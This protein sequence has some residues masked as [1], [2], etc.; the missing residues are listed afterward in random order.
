MIGNLSRHKHKRWKDKEKENISSTE[1]QEG[2]PLKDSNVDENEA[3]D[4]DSKGEP[5]PKSEGKKHLFCWFDKR[6]YSCTLFC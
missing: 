4:S 5:G 6:G 2:F 1:G 3:G